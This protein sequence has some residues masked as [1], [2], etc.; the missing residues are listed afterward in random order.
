MTEPTAAPDLSAQMVEMDSPLDS[1]LGLK[2]ELVSVDEV[3]GHIDLDPAVHMQPFGVVHGGVYAA[4]A[5][6]LAS[7]G[8]ALSAIPAGRNAM[9]LENHTSF[10]RATTEGSIFGV[11]QPLNKGRTQ[12]LWEVSI[13]DSEGRLVARSTIRLALAEPRPR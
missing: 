9:G 11:A 12:H 8:A 2:L 5:E 6:T 3:R 7:I 1:I 13:R 10:I 4:M